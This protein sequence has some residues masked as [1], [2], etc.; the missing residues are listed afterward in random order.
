MKKFILFFI[1]ISNILPFAFAAQGADDMRVFDVLYL[2]VEKPEKPVLSGL[3][4]I[5]DDLG[6]AGANLGAEDNNKTG[7][8]LNYEFAV[9]VVSA[10]EG[11]MEGAKSALE[12]SEAD[13]VLLDMTAEQIA[14]LSND[15]SERIFFNV[16]A[17]DDALRDEKCASNLFHTLPSYAMRADAIMQ[18]LRYKKWTK[19][20]LVTGHEAEDEAFANALRRS[21]EKFQIS[22]IADEAWVFD[23]DLRRAAG[24]EVP[25]FSQSLGDYDVMIVAD[26]TN[27]FARY[28]NYNTWTPR[29]IMG[30]DGLRSVGW[31]SVFEQWGAA[32]LQERFKT[33]A[34]RDMQDEDYAAWAAMRSIDEALVRTEFGSRETVYAFLLGDDFELAGF[35]GSPLSYR[36]WNAQ[37]RQPIGLASA[38]ALVASAPLEGFLHE[39]NEL[40]SLGKDRTESACTAFT[41]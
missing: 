2:R 41:Q 21:A 13:F 26:E 39:N 8:F 17:Y 37:L 16:A 24:A 3:D 36:D 22:F 40:D 30:A 10:A 23:E 38:S 35:K 34:K 7:Q 28:I 20:A 25:L 11:D 31:S 5:P 9:E 33:L 19:P 4:P 14:T 15:N 32:Q 1:A 12:E 18:F 29:P 27:D 6:I